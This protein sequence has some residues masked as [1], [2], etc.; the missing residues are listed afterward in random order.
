MIYQGQPALAND[1]PGAITCRTRRVVARNRMTYLKA[2][3]P[4]EADKERQN[5][6]DMQKRALLTLAL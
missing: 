3:V 2:Y 1:M 5:W 6:T 4:E